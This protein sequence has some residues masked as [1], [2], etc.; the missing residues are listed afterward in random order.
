LKIK[1]STEKKSAIM[2]Q[3]MSL[4]LGLFVISLRCNDLSAF[5]CKADTHK[6]QRIAGMPFSRRL[7]LSLTN[8]AEAIHGSVF[9]VGL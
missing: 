1:R 8:G 6:R 2:L 7:R 3:C 9:W 5:G 4:L